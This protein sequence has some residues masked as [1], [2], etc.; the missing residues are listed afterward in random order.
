MEQTL[1]IKHKI[2]VTAFPGG[3]IDFN[4]SSQKAT[5]KLGDLSLFWSQSG[6]F[7][8]SQKMY[9]KM[10]GF[11]YKQIKHSFM[12][13]VDGITYKV[14]D[15]G[16]EIVSAKQNSQVDVKKVN[17]LDCKIITIKSIGLAII[18]IGIVFSILAGYL[19]FSQGMPSPII[20]LPIS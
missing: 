3:P 16:I 15:E 1:S 13:S 2:V 6:E 9:P 18:A 8:F 7:G 10:S 12:I 4:V 5:V 17:T 19:M 20:A 14:K 11:D